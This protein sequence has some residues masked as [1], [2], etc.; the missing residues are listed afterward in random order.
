MALYHVWFSTKGRKPALVDEI[1]RTVR[2]SFAEVAA[3]NDIEI[4]EVETALDHVHVLISL[5]PGQTLP[6]VLHDLKGSAARRVFERLPEYASTWAAT[7]SGRRAT[8]PG[9]SR[10]NSYRPSAVTSGLSPNAPCVA[11]RR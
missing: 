6:R 5:K 1:D 10:P 7:P 2:S 8:A 9:W 3:R 11:S 4:T